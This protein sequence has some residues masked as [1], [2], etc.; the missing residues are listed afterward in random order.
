[1]RDCGNASN[2]FIQ[3]FW[4]RRW[5]HKSQIFILECKHNICAIRFELIEEEEENFPSW[6][7]DKKKKRKKLLHFRSINDVD[8]EIDVK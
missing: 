6:T 5:W 2:S 7:K 8:Y 3:L 1:M 4:N